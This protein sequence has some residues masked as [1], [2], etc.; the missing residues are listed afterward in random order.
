MNMKYIFTLASAGLFLLSGCLQEDFQQSPD[1]G[2]AL[3]VNFSRTGMANETDTNTDEQIHTLNAYRFENGILKESFKSL[4]VNNEGTC[5][6]DLEQLKGEI[7]FL[8]NGESIISKANLT[9][10]VTTLDDFLNLTATSE[11]MASEH[12]F[13]NGMADLNS[14]NTSFSVALKRAV[15]RIDLESSIQDV[16]VN[17]VVIREIALTG[18]VNEAGDKNI[19]ADIEKTDLTK[20][21][22]EHP[23]KNRKEPLYYLPEQTSNGHEVEILMTANGGWHRVKTTLPTLKRNTVYTLKVYGNGAN[24]NVEVLTDD[25]ESG[26]S[27]ESG[28]YSKDWST[29]RTHNCQKG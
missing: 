4:Q 1:S 26:D 14:G 3:T 11:E 10:D 6:L 9:D 24:L 27:S 5:R 13:M 8:A 23:F 15:A 17:S 12:L 18:L 20:D 25:W 22:G 28:L 29:K 2:R 21:F 19:L 16:E 7:Y